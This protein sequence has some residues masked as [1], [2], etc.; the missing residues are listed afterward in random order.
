MYVTLAP[1]QPYGISFIDKPIGWPW[2]P[3]KWWQNG[4]ICL[5]FV[6]ESEYTLVHLRDYIHSI[7]NSK[8]PQKWKTNKW[9]NG[10]KDPPWPKYWQMFTKKV[11]KFA[12]NKQKF[13][14]SRKFYKK[15][16]KKFELLYNFCKKVLFW[17]TNYDKYVPIQGF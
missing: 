5:F 13:S 1:E 16:Q 11:A 14:C 2:W 17:S 7:D 15:F 10:G 4:K 3:K 8:L 12:K 6:F 9:G